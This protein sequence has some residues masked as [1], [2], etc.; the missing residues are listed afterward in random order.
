MVCLCVVK[1]KSILI[2]YFIAKLI[3]NWLVQPSSA[4]LRFF[5]ILIITPTPPT[6]S[7]PPT[8]RKVVLSHFQTTQEAEIWYGSFIQPNL[9]NQLT[10]QSQASL[11]E[12][13][14]LAMILLFWPYLSH[15]QSDFNGVK[16]KFGLP[17]CYNFTSYLTSHHLESQNCYGQL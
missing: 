2:F 6:L 5:L 4:E 14:W 7:T 12:I 15:F 13:P 10:S 3:S 11:P 17:Y 16:S 8:P 9:V 1:S